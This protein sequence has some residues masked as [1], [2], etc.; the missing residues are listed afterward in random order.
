[1]TVLGAIL[2]VTGLLALLISR[3]WLYIMLLFSVPF[4]G[5][6]VFNFGSGENASSVQA[7]MYFGVLWLLGETVRWLLVPDTRVAVSIVKRSALLA[8][9]VLILTASLVM[10]L[11]IQGRLLIVSPD[12]LDFSTTPLVFHAK[13]VTSL[14][15]VVFGTLIALSI[16]RM[17]LDEKTAISTEKIWLAAGMVTCTLGTLEFLAHILHFPSPTLLFRN[18]ASPGALGYLGH[19]EGN[20][21]RVSS[22]AVEPSILSQ[23]LFTVIPLTMPALLG[24]GHVFSR[25]TDRIGLALLLV[26]LFLTTSSVAYA[27]LI[28][29]PILALPIILRLGIKIGKVFSYTMLAYFAIGF[30]VVSLYLASPA[31]R[32]LLTAA[33]FAK[34]ESYSALERLK[35]ISLGWEY[36]KAYPVLGVGW[37]SVTSHDVVV[38]I[39]ASSGILGLLAFTLAMAGI[40]RPLFLAIDKSLSATTLSRASWLLAG[41]LLIFASIIS[42]FPFVFG[43]LWVVFGMAIAASTKEY[44][45]TDIKSGDVLHDARVTPE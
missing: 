17:N 26:I 16:G 6:S 44:R 23:Y 36:F 12:L 21:T 28:V 34:S 18:S 38:M 20:I 15:Y 19:L 13:N 40:A 42:E 35:S 29:S 11:Y 10:P 30:S 31:I 7:W 8:G 5:T 27:T 45:T 25:R 43:Y 37:G 32:E 4:S 3:R 22:V 1:M 39:L 9:F 24:K 41:V 14:L 33:L 2:L